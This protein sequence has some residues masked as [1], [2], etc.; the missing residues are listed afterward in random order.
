MGLARLLDA[1]VAFEE[2]R[3]DA[4]TLEY[5]LLARAMVA[6]LIWPESKQARNL[7]VEVLFGLSFTIVR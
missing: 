5:C 2:L 4:L 1:L 7:A 6:G 3:N